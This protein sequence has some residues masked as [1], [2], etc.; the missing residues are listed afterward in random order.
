MLTVLI[1]GNVDLTVGTFMGLSGALIAGWGM[2]FGA[3]SALG[4][5][6]CLAV[7]VGLTNGFLTTRGKGLSVIV[8]LAMMTIF[9]GATL[10]YTG[11]SP[12]IDFP[13]GLRVLGAGYLGPIPWPVVVAVC[14]AV[15]LHI[16]LTHSVFGRELY[17][18]GGNMEAARLSGI[19]VQRRVI[20]TFIISALLSALAG[21]VLIGRVASAQPTA[22]LGEELNAVGA[23]LI[24]GAS[25]FGGAGSVAG[26]IAGV[27]IL[28]MISNG[29]NLLYVNPFYQYVIKG[30]IILVAI[31]MDQW[32]R[33]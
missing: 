25:L 18:I 3:L 7:A 20:T 22:G 17:A 12:I 6:L 11:G 9:E 1:T 10:L 4:L 16:M 31:L 30:L 19:P 13:E 8:T 5:G 27:L 33:K 21:L 26:V 29:L 23:V 14:A 15:L 24:G 32:G 28:G 2:Q